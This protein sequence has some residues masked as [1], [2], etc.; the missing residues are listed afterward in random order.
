MA[1]CGKIWGMLN[2]LTVKE[3]CRILRVSERTAYDLCRNGQIGG[4]VKV[5]GQWRIEKVAFE[6]WVK[7]GG[8]TPVEAAP[9][10]GGRA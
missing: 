2:F 1:N 9:K 8:G 5:G 6:K 4:A 3:V 7:R 10:R